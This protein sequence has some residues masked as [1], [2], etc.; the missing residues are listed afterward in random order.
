M[1]SFKYLGSTKN[2]D[3]SC[4]T[5]IKIRI[6]IAK[7]RMVDLH[8]LW[9][10][11]NISTG[12]KIKLVKTLVWSAL[13]YGAE[14]WTLLKADEN[15]IMAAEMWF[16]RRMLKISWK[17]KRTNLSVLQELNT[18]RDLL[19]KVARLKMGYF[20][21]ILR[22]SG[23]PLAAQ[24]IESQVEGKRKRADRESSGL[25]TSKN[26]QVSHT[27]KLKDYAQDRNNWRK[28]TRRCADVVANRQQLTAAAR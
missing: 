3:A 23:S 18:E 27:Q 5:D 10:D 17:D 13:L 26:G 20:G 21:H 22:G 28:T 4:T 12:L 1:E 15:R 24:I 16:W 25:I 7:K 14:S 2:S 8:V 9:N 11:R 19:G 6:A